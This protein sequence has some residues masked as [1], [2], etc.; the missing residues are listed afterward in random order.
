MRRP[1][2][3]SALGLAPQPARAGHEAALSAVGGCDRTLAIVTSRFVSTAGH[4]PIVQLDVA[5]LPV[6]VTRPDPQPETDQCRLE[7]E[8]VHTER[9]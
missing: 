4:H 7:H 6:E 3:R 5:D 2:I 8:R 1:C 9:K